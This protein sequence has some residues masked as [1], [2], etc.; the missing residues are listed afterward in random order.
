M[1]QNKLD[2]FA[3]AIK[4][5][6]FV[7]ENRIA[8]ELKNAGWTVISNKYYI[9]DLQETVR[10]IDLVAYCVTPIQHFNV[11]TTLII[12]C[13]KSEENAWALLS[14]EINWQDPNIDWYPLHAW[15]NDKAL[16]FQLSEPKKASS[17]YEQLASMGVKGSLGSPTVE[18]FAFQEMN[19]NSGKTHN[20][21]SIFS[22]VTSLMKAQAYE[23]AA[24][25]TRQKA[26][27]VY[28]FN[29]LS[30][31]DTDLIRLMFR[32]STIECTELETEHYL[33]RYIIHKREMFSRIRFIKADIFSSTLKDY[34]LLH[35]ANCNWFNT[36]CNL[37][38]ESVL[39]DGKRAEVLTTQFKSLINHEIPWKLA[40][41]FKRSID[42]EIISVNWS[43][44]TNSPWISVFGS[45]VKIEV[46]DFL[47][48]DPEIKD[49]VS[50]IL[51]IVYRYEGE[52]HFEDEM[53]F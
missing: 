38:Y 37:F 29:L 6:G 31:V 43:K 13:K 14:R 39:K 40:R 1:E 4:T 24:L 17:Y 36:E 52:F 46:I 16:N 28:Q 2:N 22:A 10:E 7:L 25:P 32:N 9:D 26:P 34:E 3:N 42:I 51:K 23:L 47:N 12:S 49:C 20:D 45:S 18:V 33:A 44:A 41:K 27:S 35:R 30:V 15:S 8:Q 19:K 5:T 50:K 48:S 11:Y 53:T 21:K